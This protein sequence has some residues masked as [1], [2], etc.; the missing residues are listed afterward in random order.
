MSIATLTPHDVAALLGWSDLTFTR[1]VKALVETCGFPVRMPGG[2][3]YAPAIEAW[4]ARMSGMQMEA[5]VDVLAEQRAA[6]ARHYQGRA[7]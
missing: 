5:A 3:Y 1:K 7:A 6:L 4:M 2:N